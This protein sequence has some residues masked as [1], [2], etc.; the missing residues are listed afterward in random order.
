MDVCFG[1][2]VRAVGV[3]DPSRRKHF[4]RENDVVAARQSNHVSDTT[5]ASNL[6]ALPGM[7]ERG[8]DCEGGQRLYSRSRISSTVRAYCLRAAK[9]SRMLLSALLDS[10]KPEDRAV[11]FMIGDCDGLGRKT[12]RFGAGL[13]D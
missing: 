2:K 5:T 7:L 10:V 4:G 9:V 1:I 12:G 3:S 8:G 13:A 6:Q 11:T